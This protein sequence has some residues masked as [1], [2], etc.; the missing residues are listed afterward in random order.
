MIHDLCLFQQS[1]LF[2][3]IKVLIIESRLSTSHIENKAASNCKDSTLFLAEILPLFRPNNLI[4][5]IE[6]RNWT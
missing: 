5:L 2:N 6:S 1:C 4:M 3:P